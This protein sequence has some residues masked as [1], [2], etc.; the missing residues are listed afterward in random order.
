MTN[1]KNYL[2]KIF[3]VIQY[4]F[5]INNPFFSKTKR[6]VE[7]N[8]SII[9]DILQCFCR[10]L[11]IVVLF[12]FWQLGEIHKARMLPL[13]IIPYLWEKRTVIIFQLLFVAYNFGPQSTHSICTACRKVY[14]IYSYEMHTLVSQCH[15][16]PTRRGVLLVIRQSSEHERVMRRNKGA[17]FLGGE[18]KGVPLAYQERGAKPLLRLHR[19]P[20]NPFANAA[21]R[22][23]HGNCGCLPRKHAGQRTDM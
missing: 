14:W 7:K 17:C 4:F 5:V 20:N 1:V 11:Q 10:H 9:L 12:S 6:N 23:R 18:R 2:K 3:I 16:E 19:M 21:Q 13:I 15:C 22:R 8:G